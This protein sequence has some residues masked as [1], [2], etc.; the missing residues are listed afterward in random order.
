MEQELLT[1]LEHLPEFIPGFKWGSCY[2][3][4]CFMCNVLY[5]V[6][7]LFVFFL[8][9][10]VLYVLLRITDSD[11]LP[12]VSSNSSYTIMLNYEYLVQPRFLV[13]SVL[14]NLLCCEFSFVCPLRLSLHAQ[15]C[16]CLWIVHYWLPLRFSLTFIYRD[17]PYCHFVYRSVYVGFSFI[18][19]SV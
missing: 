11:Y 16:Q 4:F 17:T 5:I 13:G 12:L 18:Q 7:C 1:L 10:I 19:V 14:F 15:C 3:I 6:V 2:S 8:F 9:V